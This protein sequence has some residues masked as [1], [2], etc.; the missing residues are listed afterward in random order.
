MARAIV[1]GSVSSAS[2]MVLARCLSSWFSAGKEGEGKGEER[3][4][5][6]VRLRSCFEVVLE[7]AGSWEVETDVCSS[8]LVEGTDAAGEGTGF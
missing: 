2:A 4:I 3:S 1:T 6:F 8:D 5:F 7:E